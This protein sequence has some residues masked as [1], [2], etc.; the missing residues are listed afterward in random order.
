MMSGMANKVGVR[1]LNKAWNWQDAH[2]SEKP[3]SQQPSCRK[4]G[5]AAPLQTLCHPFGPLLKCQALW[6]NTFNAENDFFSHYKHRISKSAY[7]KSSSF[8]CFSTDEFAYIGPLKKKKRRKKN[9]PHF[10]HL[11][12]VVF[13]Y[14]IKRN[15]QFTSLRVSFQNLVKKSRH[16]AHL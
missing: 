3:L 13:E 8:F 4:A 14:G 15:E 6:V 11:V 9:F 1:F 2:L 10:R 7:T 16:V 5:P 12:M